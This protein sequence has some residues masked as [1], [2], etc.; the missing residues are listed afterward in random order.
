MMNIAF[1][2]LSGT[3]M[4]LTLLVTASISR[5]LLTPLIHGMEASSNL[6]LK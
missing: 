6:C 1:N 5:Q 2:K 4:T 3:A